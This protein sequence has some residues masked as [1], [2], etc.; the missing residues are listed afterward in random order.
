LIK[1][2]TINN[3][4][5]F[6]K[7]EN[8]PLNKITLIG[9]KN[10]TGK[11]T[12][13]EAIFLYMDF[14]TPSVFEDFF[15]W[16]GLNG[17]WAPLKLW[18]K[19]FMDLD[20][21]NEIIISVH[22]EKND[23]GQVN[24]KFLKNY[25]TSIP[26]PITDNGV[27]TLRKNFPALEIIH[28][29][30]GSIDYQAHI[31]CQGSAYNYYKEIDQMDK[32]SSVFFMG[33]GMVLYEKNNEYLGILDKSDEQEKILP[34]LRL[35]EPNLLH[36]QLINENEKNVIYADLGNK[37]K[38]PV[39]MLG[40]G[41]CRCLTMALIMSTN[42]INVFLIDEIGAGIHY[43]IQE[44]IWK[45]LVK[46]AKLYDC[47]IIATTHRYD[48]IKAFNNIINTENFSDFSYIRL[49]KKDDII[50]PHIFTAET[51][52]YALTSELEIR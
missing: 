29:F 20:F 46:A 31:L 35:L 30:N 18:E 42:N 48:T 32:S 50:K 40:N 23:N 15:S 41:F 17:I 25:E 26:I 24:F 28:T 3:F 13:L 51:L 12:F 47:Q 37:K 9:G 5:A 19:F 36:L 6:K 16:R 44:N 8:V 21:N 38:I 43:S 2:I 49:G 22:S 4:K 27:T 14:M 11:T 34:L 45:F 33:E 52:N 10:N 39:N 1:S 7:L